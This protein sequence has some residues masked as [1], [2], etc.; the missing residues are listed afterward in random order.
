MEVN[1]DRKDS[2]F[3]TIK[4]EVDYLKNYIFLIQKRFGECI[5]FETEVSE[6]LLGYKLLRLILQPLVENAITHGIEPAGE[7]MIP[8]K[9]SKEE[10]VLY[11]VI[12]D[13]GEG[14]DTERLKYI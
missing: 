6:E 1:I 7:G 13:M 4:E 2:S 10:T 3:L 8:V 5:R 9:V 11:I 12:E 14:I